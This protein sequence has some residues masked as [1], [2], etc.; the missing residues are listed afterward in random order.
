MANQ[1]GSSGYQPYQLAQAPAQAIAPYDPNQATSSTGRNDA[2]P[3]GMSAMVDLT[4]GIGSAAE[5]REIV[6]TAEQADGRRITQTHRVSRALFSQETQNAQDRCSLLQNEIRAIVRIANE[7]E[8]WWNRNVSSLT[9]HT[10][11]QMEQREALLQNAMNRWNDESHSLRRSAEQAAEQARFFQSEAHTLAANQS[12]QIGA[13]IGEANASAFEVQELRSQLS[14][15]V[16]Q[17]ECLEWEQAGTL[18]EARRNAKQ[19]QA[20]SEAGQK[21]EAQSMMTSKQI[22]DLNRELNYRQSK[23]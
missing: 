11:T 1:G 6:V 4:D 5:T 9:A 18:E 20:M 19:M 13:A 12:A 16:A 14:A 23:I 17:S 10:A 15:A 21:L 8:D 2:A 7:R 3:Q 22:E